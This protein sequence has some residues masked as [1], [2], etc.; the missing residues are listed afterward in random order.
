[1]QFHP[2]HSYNMVMPQNA[3]YSR[4]PPTLLSNG[5]GAMTPPLHSP[6]LS[7]GKPNIMVETELRDGDAYYPQTPPLSC[8]ASSAGS[9]ASVGM[10]TPINPMFVP[11]MDIHGLD[12][13]FMG[14]KHPAHFAFGAPEST[15]PCTPMFYGSITPAA[16]SPVPS[17]S[18]S[19]RPHSRAST[20]DLQVDF[21]NPRDLT[22]SLSPVIAPQE[23]IKIES[24][25]TVPDS[26]EPTQL[27]GLDSVA[28]DLSFLPP[29]RKSVV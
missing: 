24:P 28:D 8:S 1:M 27:D 20:S 2:H 21:C 29:D 25:L 26:W 5:H 15:P 4:Q 7:I 10:P 17:L 22:N 19:P 12:L 18:P 3:V 9:P 16:N 23:E 6:Q 11:M 14:Q 13:D